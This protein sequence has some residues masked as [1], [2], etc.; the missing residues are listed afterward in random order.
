MYWSVGHYLGI[1]GSRSP[2]RSAISNEFEIDLLGNPKKAQDPK[3][4]GTTRILR[5]KT[6][7][8]GDP[9]LCTES[10]RSNWELLPPRWYSAHALDAY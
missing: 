5:L 6:M 3:F 1:G 9:V 2:R 8:T 10:V 7:A 4:C